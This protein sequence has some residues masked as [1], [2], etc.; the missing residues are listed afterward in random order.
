MTIKIKVNTRSKQNLVEPVANDE[1][2]FVVKV[3]VPPENNKAN[4]EIIKMLADYF[5]VA[6]NSITIV[7]GA[8]GNIKTIS[9][10]E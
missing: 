8:K 4:Y 5:H 3:N 7:Q 6:K 1:Y 9:I 2:Q 10:D